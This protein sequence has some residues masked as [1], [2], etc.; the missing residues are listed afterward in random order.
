MLIL[1]LLLNANGFG[2]L[3]A[4]D[5]FFILSKHY[6]SLSKSA[7]LIACARLLIIAI[8]EVSG[9][10]ACCRSLSLVM[11]KYPLLGCSYL[12]PIGGGEL[13]LND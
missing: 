5:G 6:S 4:F 7:L 13:R 2:R 9:A 8:C 1:L 11:M 10:K 3:I 12:A